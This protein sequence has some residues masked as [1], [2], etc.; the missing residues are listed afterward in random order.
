MARLRAWTVLLAAGI[1]VLGIAGAASADSILPSAPTITPLGGGVYQWSYILTIDSLQIIPSTASGC[2]TTGTAGVKTN[3]NF[4]T[5]FDAYGLTGSPSFT[6]SVSGLS[7]AVTTP[8]TGP[9][10]FLA[11]PPDSSGV[12]NVDVAFTNSSG[13]SIT[14][15]ALGTLTF[16]STQSGGLV[17]FY[18]AQADTSSAGNTVT[19][20]QGTVLLPAPEPASL[21]LLGPGLLGLVAMRRR[22]RETA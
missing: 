11:G 21:A 16:D 19:G 1:A 20:N 17:G 4:F 2:T 13:G 7:G 6:S 3:C 5:L 10:A 18:S 22:R 15:T 9:V 12:P 14:N 8:L